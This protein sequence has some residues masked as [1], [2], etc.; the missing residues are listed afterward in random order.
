MIVAAYGWQEYVHT[1][2]LAGVKV[3]RIFSQP[4]CEARHPFPSWRDVMPIDFSGF[5]E[6]GGAD[7]VNYSTVRT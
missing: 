1:N 7:T 2:N 3:K 4:R 5:Q 6:V